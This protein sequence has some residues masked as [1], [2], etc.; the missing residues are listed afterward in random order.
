[1]SERLAERGKKPS[2]RLLVMKNGM[3]TII[4]VQTFYMNGIMTE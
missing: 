4:C 3:P 1:M 2:L